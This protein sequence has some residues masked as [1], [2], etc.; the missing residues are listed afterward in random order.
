MVIQQQRIFGRKTNCGSKSSFSL[1][2]IP[3]SPINQSLTHG[4]T[5]RFFGN[6]PAANA[7]VYARRALRYAGIRV[8]DS[9]QLDSKLYKKG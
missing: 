4:R 7:G 6:R 3:R 2:L 8:H 9:A 5:I 1:H